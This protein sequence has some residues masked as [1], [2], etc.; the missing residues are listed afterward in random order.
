ML[1][2]SGSPPLSTSI[3]SSLSSLSSRSLLTS[4]LSSHLLSPPFR[5]PPKILRE[6]RASTQVSQH[7]LR[8]S[9]Q[10]CTLSSGQVCPTTLCYAL[11]CVHTPERIGH[12]FTGNI[13]SSH[14]C[15]YCRPMHPLRHAVLTWRVFVPGVDLSAIADR[16]Q[17]RAAVHSGLR[18]CTA[19][20]SLSR[21]PENDA[22]KNAKSQSNL[23]QRRFFLQPPARLVP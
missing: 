3:I 2:P 8:V 9:C 21:N 11:I 23:N 10:D 5:I 22:E 15:Q 4:S 14:L 6:K 13:I 18:P 16:M 12:I 20:K 19:P 7:C 17:I 1:D